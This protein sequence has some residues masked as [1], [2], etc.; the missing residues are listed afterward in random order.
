LHELRLAHSKLHATLAALSDGD[1]ARELPKESGYPMRI[2][3]FIRLINRHDS[4]HGGQ[5]ALARRLFK[6]T[7]ERRRTSLGGNA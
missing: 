1:L 6:E 3:A 7:P 2:D 4:W 5:I